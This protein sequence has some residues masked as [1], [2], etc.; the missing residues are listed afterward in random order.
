MLRFVR[1]RKNQSWIV[2]HD[3]ALA[4]IS[5]LV[6]EFLAKIKIVIMPQLPN[7][8]HMTPVDFFLSSKLQTSMKDAG[9]FCYGCGNKR[10][11]II[12]AIGDTKKRLSELFRGLEQTLG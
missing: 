3:S 1:N 2:Y 9:A 8:P 10:K 12:G 5:M 6:R 7:S 11:I 4:H